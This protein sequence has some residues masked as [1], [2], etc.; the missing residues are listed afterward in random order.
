MGLIAVDWGSSSFR[1]Y[2]LNS[3]GDIVESQASG[4][5][6][7]TVKDGNFGAVLKRQCGAWLEAWPDAPVIMSGM[8]GSRNGWCEV[9][10]VE[11]PASVGD[12]A[13]NR[14]ALEQS[15]F[16]NISIV[17]GVCGQ[18]ASGADDVMRGEEVQIVGA[19]E[20]TGLADTLVCLPGTHSKWACVRRGAIRSFSTLLTGEMYALLSNH[21]TLLNT[22]DGSGAEFNHQTFIDGVVCSRAKGGLLHHVFSTR[23]R[24]LTGKMPAQDGSAFLSGV[25]IGNELSAAREMH[26]EFD[27]AVVVGSDRLQSLYVTAAAI[28]GMSLGE[29]DSN[30]ATVKGLMA[31]N[32]E[33]AG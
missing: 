26:P 2:R 3:D 12:L 9:P 16:G 11:C 17:P 32:N 22:V 27:S 33:L 7:F 13:K 31:V 24:V 6:V 5:G 21:S 1:A 19:L 20:L 25:L 29:V 14:V 10:Y 23:A 18:S 4:D 28:Y 15:G 30:A 8:I